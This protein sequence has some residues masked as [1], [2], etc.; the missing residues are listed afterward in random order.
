MQKYSKEIKI[1][2]FQKAYEATCKN[3]ESLHLIENEI[4][5]IDI[6]KNNDKLND[7]WNKYQDKFAYASNISF[8]EI[9]IYIKQLISYL[10]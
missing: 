9:I 4:T 5:I 2:E 1:E 7:L 6:I 3:R 10:H 8:N